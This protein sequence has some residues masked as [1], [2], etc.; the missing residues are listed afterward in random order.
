MDQISCDNEQLG[1]K[2]KTIAI[3]DNYAVVE[4]L[5]GDKEDNDGKI[6][7]SII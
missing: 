3:S 4:F 5:I 2:E 1:D 7:T 6:L